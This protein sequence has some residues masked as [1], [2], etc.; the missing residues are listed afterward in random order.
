MQ[1]QTHDSRPVSSS[2][3]APGNASK[4]TSTPW[5]PAD[6]ETLLQARA[7]GL[8]WAPIQ[9]QFFP[10]KTPNACRKR[11]ERLMEKRS[12]EDYDGV[13]LET[14]ARAYAEVRKEM[15]GVLANRVG[16][17]WG[18]VEQKV[19]STQGTRNG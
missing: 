5:I 4:S 14:L 2:A 9:Q 17:K 6:D 1:E 8:N 10:N 12:A 3:H 13:R 18:V 11:H 7:S 19:S 15:W 16:E